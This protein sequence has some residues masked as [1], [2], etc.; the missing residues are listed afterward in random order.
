MRCELKL[1]ERGHALRQY[2]QLA[3]CLRDELGTAPAPET[4]ALYLRL[5]RGD[6]D[7]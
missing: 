2:Q 7:R 1:G 5:R 6:A 3:R 4:T